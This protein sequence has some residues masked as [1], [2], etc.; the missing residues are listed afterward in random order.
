M[1]GKKSPSI[2]N[3]SGIVALF[4]LAIPFGRDV[5]SRRN[6]IDVTPDKAMSFI[7]EIDQEEEKRPS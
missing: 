6:T 1:S 5:K 2:G 4:I 3:N 7:I